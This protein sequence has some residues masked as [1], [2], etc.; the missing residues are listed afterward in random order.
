MSGAAAGRVVRAAAE[1]R[2]RVLFKDPFSYCAHPHI[3]ALPGGELVMVFNRA[4]RRK[5]ILHPPQELQRRDTLI[6]RGRDLER[7]AGRAGL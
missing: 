2:H 1:T 6:R 4:P 7:A 5:F 3:A